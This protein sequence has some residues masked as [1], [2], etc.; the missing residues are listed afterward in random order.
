ML[1]KARRQTYQ[2]LARRQVLPG[3]VLRLLVGIRFQVLFTPLTRVLFAFPSR[4]LF[5]IGRQECLA[6]EGGP[7]CFPL[8]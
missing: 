5:T 7:P 8:D 1:R 3:I 2:R 6:L 4:Y